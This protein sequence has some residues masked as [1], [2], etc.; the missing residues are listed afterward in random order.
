M[1][2]VNHNNHTIAVVAICGL[3]II[4]SIALFKG[5]NGIMFGT[6][7]AVIAGIAGFKLKGYMK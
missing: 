4:E 3:V 6:T 7:A 1:V 2:C 5:I